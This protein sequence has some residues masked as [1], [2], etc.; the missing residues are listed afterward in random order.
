M[1]NPDLQSTPEINKASRP[2][3]AII[4][5]VSTIYGVSPRDVLGRS[6]LGPINA[7]RIAYYLRAVDE[8]DSS[9]PQIGRRVGRDHSTVLKVV[10]RHYPRVNGRPYEGRRA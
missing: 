4:E 2:L 9:F 7:A 6:K 3:L 1:D 10:Q 8:T 5:E